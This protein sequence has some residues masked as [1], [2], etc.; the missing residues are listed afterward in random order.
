[1]KVSAKALSENFAL[2][3]LQ[4]CIQQKRSKQ[5]SRGH[6]DS[7][8]PAAMSYGKGHMVVIPSEA[9][10]PSFAQQKCERDSSL[11][12]EWR[13]INFSADSLALNTSLVKDQ[14]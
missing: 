11:R 10:N 9:R 1:V 14:E 4:F 13:V 2:S 8:P 3:R 6:I 12:A 7:R 5:L